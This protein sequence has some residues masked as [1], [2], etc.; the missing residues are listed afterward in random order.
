M[1]GG[2]APDDAYRGNAI[3][4]ADTG[5]RSLFANAI[6]S[7]TASTCA[8]GSSDAMHTGGWALRSPSRAR[9]LRHRC[10]G[11]RWVA[12]SGPT[13]PH[14]VPS[15]SDVHV[16]GGA[17][18]RGERQPGPLAG[19]RGSGCEQAHRWGPQSWPTTR[20]SLARGRAVSS[21][22]GRLA[23][24]LPLQERERGWRCWAVGSSWCAAGGGWPPSFGD[25]QSRAQVITR[26]REVVVFSSQGGVTFTPPRS[27]HGR[28]VGG[29]LRRRRLDG[30][31][32][33]PDRRDRRR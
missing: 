19:H 6:V 8:K 32:V 1:A 30:A 12:A 21:Q 22:R 26:G 13:L 18:S 5:G 2:G 33:R 25:E 16:S 15:I 17:R 14:L 27:G 3:A 10:T 28:P 23:R 20:C 11:R 9:R 31:L 4:D 7:L 29:R 24:R